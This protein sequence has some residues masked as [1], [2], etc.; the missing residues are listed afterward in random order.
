MTSATASLLFTVALGALVG[1]A[2]PTPAA[3]SA[4]LPGAV[5][6]A[7]PTPVAPPASAPSLPLPP[8]GPVLPV[9]PGCLAMIF[10][11]PGDE[12][13]VVRNERGR[14]TDVVA[15]S[16]RKEPVLARILWDELETLVPLIADI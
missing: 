11:A 4:P 7:P 10:V 1:C 6:S 9:P 5:A 12:R 3:P 13:N 2:A 14:I 15:P 16:G 8:P